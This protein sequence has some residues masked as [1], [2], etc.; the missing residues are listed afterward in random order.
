M[1]L[2]KESGLALLPDL[3]AA[4]PDAHIVVLTGFAS[5]ATAA[6]AVKSGAND[7]LPKPIL[8]RDLLAHFSVTTS[9]EVRSAE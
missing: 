6:R 4:L 8:L 3:R 9:S 7:H 1:R 2:A 5:I